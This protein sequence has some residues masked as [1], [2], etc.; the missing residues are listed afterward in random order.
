VYVK[1]G[2]EVVELPAEKNC[3]VHSLSVD[4]FA[5]VINGTALITRPKKENNTRSEE[6]FQ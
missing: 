1:A 6:V 2:I 4:D 5:V 3:T